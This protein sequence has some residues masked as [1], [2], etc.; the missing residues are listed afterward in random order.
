MRAFNANSV[1]NVCDRLDVVFPRVRNQYFSWS[2]PPLGFFLHFHTNVLLLV[3]FVKTVVTFLIFFFHSHNSRSVYMS[4]VIAR[5]VNFY[6][7]IVFFLFTQRKH[8]LN[9]SFSSLFTAVR[10]RVCIW[11]THF[12][13]HFHSC[14]LSCLFCL[15]S[16][17][18]SHRF[19]LSFLLFVKLWHFVDVYYGCDDG[20]DGE[21]AEVCEVCNGNAFTMRLMDFVVFK[22]K[23]ISSS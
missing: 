12:V 9:K 8:P 19:D 7:E 5:C 23:T 18:L 10:T 1:A 3:Q 17:S 16:L 2:L 6:Q 4:C 21:F 13:Y 22:F 14:Y 15:A 11:Y 20:N